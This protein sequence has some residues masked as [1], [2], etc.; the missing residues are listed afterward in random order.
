MFK[1]YILICEIGWAGIRRLSL[2]LACKGIASYILINGLPDTEVRQ[3][4]SRHKGANNIFIPDKFFKPFMFLYIISN[5]VM[6]KKILLFVE[7][8]EKTFKKLERLRRI[9]NRIELTRVY[10]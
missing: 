7:S 5:I 4:I 10:D 9:F 6:N 3:M 2:E 8:K 1:R